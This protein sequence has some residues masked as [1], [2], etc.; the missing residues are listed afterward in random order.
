[1]GWSAWAKVQPGMAIT[2]QTQDEKNMV[3]ANRSSL[4]GFFQAETNVGNEPSVI[5]DMLATIPKFASSKTF[6]RMMPSKPPP[7]LTLSSQVQPGAPYF[8]A[9]PT[10]T[11]EPANAPR[12]CPFTLCLASMPARVK[13]SSAVQTIHED[14]DG[15]VL[16]WRMATI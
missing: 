14:L 16:F 15:R 12:I 2:A 10:V 13:P 7:K 3:Q 11:H 1:M 8:R 4:A 9:S 6:Q 5:T